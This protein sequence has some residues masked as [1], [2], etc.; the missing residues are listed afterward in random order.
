MPYQHHE[1]H[2]R[3]RVPDPEAGYA[4]SP[5]SP[6]PS[7]SA[8]S[9]AFPIRL[10]PSSPIRLHSPYPPNSAPALPRALARR[11][12]AHNGVLVALASPALPCR[13]AT[14]ACAADAALDIARSLQGEGTGGVAAGVALCLLPLAGAWWYTGR[15]GVLAAL[16]GA[17]VTLSLVNVALVLA[18]GRADAALRDELGRCRQQSRV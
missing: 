6:T 15:S 7:A 11:E 14:L 2:D 3:H 1:H 8:P 17:A 10:Y 16:K 9:L 12:H 4:S 18:L 13:E 5:P